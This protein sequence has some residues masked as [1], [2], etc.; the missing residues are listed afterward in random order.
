MLHFLAH[1]FSTGQCTDFPEKR[2]TVP[3]VSE[4]LAP[5]NRESHAVTCGVKTS[6]EKLHSFY[7]DQTTDCLT[8][9][10][11]QMLAVLFGFRFESRNDRR[12]T[13]WVPHKLAAR[14][15]LL[16][17]DVAE[18]LVEVVAELGSMLLPGSPDFIYQR[19]IRLNCHCQR[20]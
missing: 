2:K 11:I 9:K 8:S 17:L 7:R 15:L 14:R 3:K 4:S 1:G 12:R 16:R 10:D 18:D 20:P 6:R 19:I 5:V 13:R